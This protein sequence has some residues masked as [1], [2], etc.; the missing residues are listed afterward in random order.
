MPYPARCP[1]CSYDL[2]GA[3][4]LARCPECGTGIAV[5]TPCLAIGCVPKNKAGPRW[6]K[7]VWTTIMVL[8][9]LILYGWPYFLAV[10]PWALGVGILACLVGAGLMMMTGTSA[11][12]S[13]EYV[14]FTPTGMIRTIW[15]EPNSTYHPWAG[16]EECRG[17][18]IGGFWQRLWIKDEGG[19]VIFD[20]GFR[21][22]SES[23]GAV[24]AA[25]ERYI[26]GEQPDRER[27]APYIED[28][29]QPK[30]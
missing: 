6:R 13:T 8:A 24:A 30:S 11:A 1:Q 26:R 10:Q 14:I 22:R 2:T 15:G 5:G 17:K 9:G 27:F 12:T 23:L 21:C 20:C 19:R 4:K 25:T 29:L 16:T 7:V 28:R 18:R 3:E